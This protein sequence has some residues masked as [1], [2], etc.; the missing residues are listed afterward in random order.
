MVLILVVIWLFPLFK[1]LWIGVKIKIKIK[2]IIE[3]ISQFI[4]DI[5]GIK[6]YFG[7]FSLT[8]KYNKFT[9]I[10][11]LGYNLILA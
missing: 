9:N 11:L 4:G 8:V 10:F 5:W 1:L 7:N 3:I 2:N 6:M